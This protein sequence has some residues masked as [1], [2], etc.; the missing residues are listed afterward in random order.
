MSNNEQVH[1]AEDFT[2]LRKDP[3]GFDETVG[4]IDALE[5]ALSGYPPQ[6]DDTD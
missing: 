2:T 1:T 3:V 4:T 5:K 6:Y